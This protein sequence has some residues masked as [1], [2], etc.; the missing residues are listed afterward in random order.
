MNIGRTIIGLCGAALVLASACAWGEVVAPLYVG[1]L[2]PALDQNGRVLTGSN[3]SADAAKRCRVELRLAP[4]AKIQPPA[5][6][7]EAQ[8]DNP[9]VSPSSVGGIGMNTG[10]TNS[11]LFCMVFP[12]R[13]E[14]GTKV[15]AR[16][17][18]APT[19]EEASFF[20]DSN[21]AAA[22]AKNKTSL[23]LTFGAAQPL[24]S[25]DADG[26]GLNNSWEKALGINDRLT[27][28]YDGDGMSDLQ[29]MRAGTNPRD[30][31]A[32]LAFR[33]IREETSMARANADGTAIKTM[34]VRFQT[35]PGKSYQLQFASTLVGAQTFLPAG[36]VVTAA[37]DESEIDLLV[38]LP[39]GSV[40]GMFRVVLIGAE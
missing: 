16:V 33:S 31:G 40:S 24:D 26:D 23:A 13:I 12:N 21:I 2:I 19:L 4:N 14:Q 1:N 3:R 22:P 32:L 38:E 7:G 27:S 30:A 35:V 34:R 11:G 6:T 39:A 8:V 5:A 9:L 36:D 20:A 25:G 28:D 18:N 10:T 17:Y 37:A 29:E 15:F